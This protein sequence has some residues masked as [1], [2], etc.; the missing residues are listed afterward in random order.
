MAIRIDLSELGEGQFIE[1]KDPKFLSWG[2]Q[3]EITATVMDK[4]E[5]SAQLDIAEKITIA[6]VKTGNVFNEDGMP[7]NFPLT[8]ESIKDVPAAIIEKV[9]TKFAEF[10]G[11][12]PDRKN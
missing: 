8:A 11:Q 9:S 5:A 1:M 3:K 6:L 7:I 10:K 2:V 4:K 12:N